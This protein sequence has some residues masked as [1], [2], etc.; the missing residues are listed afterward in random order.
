[1]RAAR[2]SRRT[3]LR[4]PGDPLGEVGD[5]AALA[6]PPSLRALGDAAFRGEGGDDGMAYGAAKEAGTAAPPP[7]SSVAAVRREPR[8][9]EGDGAQ[10]EA[11]RGPYDVG[12]EDTVW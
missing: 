7:S 10:L 6:A 8:P 9:R 11:G 4:N 2:K 3:D 1:M 12:G 5:V